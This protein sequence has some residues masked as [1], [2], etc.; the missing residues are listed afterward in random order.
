MCE[1]IHK[2][3]L[4]N[5]YYKVRCYYEIESKS[6][7]ECLG[8]TSE[9]EFHSRIS[10]YIDTMRISVCK[11]LN[12]LRNQCEKIIEIETHKLFDYKLWETVSI[13][14][15]YEYWFMQYKKLKSNG[16]LDFIEKYIFDEKVD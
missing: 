15:T 14:D 9:Y 3:S 4:E 6:Y 1:P 2:N 5:T 8:F 7:K 12:I 10:W 16:E 13:L 11:S